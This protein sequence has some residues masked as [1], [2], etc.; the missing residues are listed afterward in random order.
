MANRIDQDK[1]GRAGKVVLTAAKIGLGVWVSLILADVLSFLYLYLST[2]NVLESYGLPEYGAKFV[3]VLFAAPVAYY[4]NNILWKMIKRDKRW[5]PALTSVM[6]LWFGIMFLVSS[7]YEN[8]AFNIFS[9][10]AGKYYRDQYKRIHAVPSG[11]KVGP[12]GEEVLRF[13]RDAAQEYERQQGIRKRSFFGKSASNTNEVTSTI[14]GDN[15]VL[16]VEKMEIAPD[17]TIIYLA[18]AGKDGKPGWLRYNSAVNA[19]WRGQTYNW[20]PAQEM[21]PY[22]AD[23]SGQTYNLRSDLAMYDSFQTSYTTI[24]GWFKDSVHEN[25]WPAHQVRVDEIYRFALIFGTVR[26]ETSRLRLHLHWF[27][28]AL[29]LDDALIRAEK[30]PAIPPPQPPPPPPPRVAEFIPPPQPI[31]PVVIPEPSAQPVLVP[32]PDPTPVPSVSSARQSSSPPAS[33]GFTLGYREL[34]PGPTVRTGTPITIGP[35]IKSETTKRASRPPSSTRRI[36][37]CPIGGTGSWAA[38]LVPGY[39]ELLVD[40]IN[41]GMGRTDL[42]VCARSS[43][44][45]QVGNLS[46]AGMFPSYLTDE[47]GRVYKF[48]AGS[49]MYRLTSDLVDME[50]YRRNSGSA[51]LLQVGRVYQ[52][53]IGFDSLVGDER[54]LTLHRTNYP[55]IRLGRQLS[56]RSATQPK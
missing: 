8:N 41:T 25:F 36:T 3:A 53:R 55:P 29:D 4:L 5:I 30:I 9:G 6:A 51:Y 14:V 35:P 56:E 52:F 21:I 10:Q 17:R 20:F 13:D 49:D 12:N 47:K 48:R 39:P 16:W 44:Q 26:Q 19:V 18:C 23:D 38:P 28:P 50:P 24:K 7:P 42:F 31:V 32:T 15:L 45:L 27:K 11:A 34:P 43:D 1:L 54:E 2:A 37:I 46:D 33:G 40:W 22:L